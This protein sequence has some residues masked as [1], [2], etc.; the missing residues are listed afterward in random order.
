ME[1]KIGKFRAAQGSEIIEEIAQKQVLKEEGD[2]MS[3]QI[4]KEIAINPIKARDNIHQ[5]IL[6]QSIDST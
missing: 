1:S 4:R 2:S 3:R 6:D 5:M